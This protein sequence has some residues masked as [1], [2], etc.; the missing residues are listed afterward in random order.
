MTT[1]SAIPGF[2][3]CC[4]VNRFDTNDCTQ[5]ITQAKHRLHHSRTAPVDR[6][7]LQ[8]GVWAEIRDK[9]TCVFPGMS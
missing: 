6:T 1:K 2:C 8:E 4:G 3:F 9:H 7:D 5:D